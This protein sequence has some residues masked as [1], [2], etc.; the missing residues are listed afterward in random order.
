M[1]PYIH[2]AAFN[3]IGTN[4]MSTLA[5]AL[6]PSAGQSF[7]VAPPPLRCLQLEGN[8]LGPK[9]AGALVDAILAAA[10]PPQVAHLTIAQNRLGNE[11]AAVVARLFT[12]WKG[13]DGC[14]ETNWGVG[15]VCIRVCYAAPCWWLTITTRTNAPISQ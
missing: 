12:E 6:F 4:G 2:T 7:T 9:G 14:V 10:A 11:G 3:F 1:Q 5:P 15:A 13:E 8:A